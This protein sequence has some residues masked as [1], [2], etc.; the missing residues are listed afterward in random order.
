MYLQVNV[1][2]KQGGLHPVITNEVQVKQPT[3]LSKTF[4]QL[5]LM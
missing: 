2:S 5:K 3:L 4:L 1:N